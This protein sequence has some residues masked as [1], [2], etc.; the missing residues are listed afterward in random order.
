MVT[1]IMTSV[2]W[3]VMPCS[4]EEIYRYFGRM[5]YLHIHSTVW[6]LTDE[7]G[8]LFWQTDDTAHTQTAKILNIR[9]IR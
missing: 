6:Q 1:V 5:C 2:F 4:L 8:A 3:D 7:H 9:N